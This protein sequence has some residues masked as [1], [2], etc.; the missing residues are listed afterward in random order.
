MVLVDRRGLTRQ[1][2]PTVAASRAVAK[3]QRR[4]RV[5]IESV[6]HEQKKLKTTVRQRKERLA[7]K[8]THGQISFQARPPN[9]YT[10]IPAGNPELTNA[11]K[12]A[13][14]E[15]SQ[16]IYAVSVSFACG[17]IY[18]FRKKLTLLVR[19]LLMHKSMIFPKRYIALASTSL[20]L[21][22]IKSALS[23]VSP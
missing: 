8:L 1:A 12:E 16:Q 15:A 7:R 21:S 11:L 20:Q 14:R 18:C 10:F 9:G 5:I 23:T 2:L 3:K 4:H 17:S 6:G 22:S 19:L 13:S